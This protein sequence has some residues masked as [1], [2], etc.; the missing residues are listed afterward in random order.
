MVKAD[1]KAQREKTK[2]TK[3]CWEETEDH[4]GCDL[5]LWVLFESFRGL[6]EDFKKY[7]GLRNNKHTQTDVFLLY[8]VPTMIEDM[9]I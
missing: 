5:R 6:S 8:N 7:N 9:E 4:T 2:R 1:E 3:L